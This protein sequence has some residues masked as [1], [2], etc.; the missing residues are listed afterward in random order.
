MGG[1]FLRFYVR[2]NQRHDHRLLWEWLLEQANRMGIRG[3]SAFRAMAGFGQHH[4]LHEDHFFEL[5]GT[6]TVEVEFIVADDEAQ[7]LLDRLKAEKIRVFYTK[8]PAQFGITV[9]DID[10]TSA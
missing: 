1:S 5:A 9:P 10:E 8:I 6:L 2:E 7:K 3:G 4:Q